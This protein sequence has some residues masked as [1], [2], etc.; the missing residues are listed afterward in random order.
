MKIRQLILLALLLLAASL[1]AKDYTEDN[2]FG[3]LQDLTTDRTKIELCREYYENSTEMDIKRRVTGVWGQIDKASLMLEL[4]DKMKDDKKNKENLYLYARQ[5]EDV[6]EAVKLGRK[7]IK[8]DETWEYGY[9]LVCAHYSQ[10]LFTDSEY[11]AKLKK[12]YK[13]DKQ[14]FETY[15]D[16][17]TSDFL[18]Q[19]VYLEY[20]KYENRANEIFTY[21]A[22]ALE[23]KEPWISTRDLV[24]YKVYFDADEQEVLNI[25][26]KSFTEK[27]DGYTAEEI[28][29]MVDYT[30][31]D[32]LKS[33]SKYIKAHDFADKIGRAS[34]RERV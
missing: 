14:Y 22:E 15:K 24:S 11:S 28:S 8:L 23:K 27:R 33:N 26:E 25:L 13:K 18:S 31:L 1:F 32:I 12:S 19:N 10:Y 34:C 3:E 7:I 5:V 30:Y 29:N 20:L 9:R 16:F 4:E 2:F 21:I 17:T 6:P